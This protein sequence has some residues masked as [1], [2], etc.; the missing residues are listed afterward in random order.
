MGKEEADAVTRLIMD[1]ALFRI[2][3]K[4]EEVNNFEKEF[5]EYM[6]VEHCLCLSSGTG[7]LMAAMAALG[8]GP[9]DEVI[10]PGYT[11][12]ATAVAVL[13]V[14][15]IPVL[16]EVDETLTLD[17]KDV[18]AKISKNT[19]AVIPVHIQGFP[20]NMDALAALKKKHNFY[21]IEDACQSDGGS[22][23]GKRLGT[24]GDCG[25]FSF[26]YFKII[27]SGEG[28]ALVTH[29]INVFQRAIIYH[30]CGTA[31]WSYPQPITEPLFT[32]VNMRVSEITG[33]IMRVQLTRLEGILSD[34]RRIKKQILDGV[35]GVPGI[36][37]NPSNDL[38][39]DCGVCLPLIFDTAQL[40]EK[41]EQA[42]KAAGLDCNRPINTGKHVYSAWTPVLE[43]RGAHITGMNPYFSPENANLHKDVST[44]S[45]PKTLDCLSRTVYLMI[46]C[47]WNDAEVNQKIETL[48]TAAKAL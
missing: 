22:Y 26:N 9:G 31:F 43:K 7:A 34:L 28:G 47:D 45:C 29:D 24:I 6:G 40:A 10:I 16:A 8:I 48:K 23:K 44:D 25:A 4:Y 20:T 11:F 37:P 36:R 5:R 3:G 12:I 17:M 21:I 14:G 2:G 13:A 35:S 46:N 1:K 39:G 15:A 33:A 18:E 42:V 41:F 19:K 32:G 38:A 27:S 30:D